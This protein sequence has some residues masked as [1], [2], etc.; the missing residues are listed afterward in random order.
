MA[1]Q[2]NLPPP[3]GVPPSGQNVFQP[4][5]GLIPL[6]G[7]ASRKIEQSLE[8]MLSR[9]LEIRKNIENVVHLM[10][11][12]NLNFDWPTALSNFSLISGE[13]Y[14]FK[15]LIMSENTPEL[16]DYPIVPYKLSQD[17]D[18]HLQK[19]TQGRVP[20]MSHASAPDYL[21]TKP[22]PQVEQQE[23]NINSL[24][25]N[26]PDPTNAIKQHNKVCNN[27]WNKI[28]NRESVITARNS[29]QE[30]Y[31]QNVSLTWVGMLKHGFGSNQTNS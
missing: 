15:Q 14:S 2:T 24:V 16:R 4:P 20:M 27:V 13:I 21:R 28:V 23:V 3:S 11:N 10:E 12:P 30:T 25:S 17:T 7:M 1:S 5:S 31:D 19:L 8:N 26:N 6:Q 29:Q 9:S 22:D 18:K